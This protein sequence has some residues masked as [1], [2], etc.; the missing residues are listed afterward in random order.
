VGAGCLSFPFCL[1]KRV[2]YVEPDLEFGLWYCS[3]TIA[4]ESMGIPT[5]FV[6]DL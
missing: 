2:V 6:R 4:Y 5:A 3:A 1:A